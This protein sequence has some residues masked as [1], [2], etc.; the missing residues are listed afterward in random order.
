M[1]DSKVPDS[2]S[3]DADFAL[4]VL[5]HVLQVLRKVD[6]LSTAEA[7]DPV[8][9]TVGT[10]QTRV[11]HDV[12][13]EQRRSVVVVGVVRSVVVGVVGVVVAIGDIVVANTSV[14]H[15]AVRVRWCRRVTIVV[16]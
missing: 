11:A 16:R 5:A 2:S 1:S 10:E 8:E 7:A 3:G 12:A 9:V 6:A 14:H 13:A 4:I 15:V